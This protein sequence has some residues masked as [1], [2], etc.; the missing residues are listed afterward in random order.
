MRRLAAGEV[1][2]LVVAAAAAR[3]Q[4]DP[5]EFA[6]ELHGFAEPL[7]PA[8]ALD[9][10]LTSPLKRLGRPATLTLRWSSAQG[11]SGK[12]SFRATARVR[13]SYAVARRAL[14]ARTAIDAGVLE[15]IEGFLPGEPSEFLLWKQDVEGKKL[16][17]NLR[18][19]E[20]L[21]RR[22]LEQAPAVE[23]GALLE[24]ELRSRAVVLRAAARAEQAGSPGQVIR[25]RTLQSGAM[26][27]ARLRDARLGEVVP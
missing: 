22:M 10:E 18:P 23:R 11:Q 2:D 9:F 8:G 19:G 6:V 20:V 3:Y 26:V 14:A 7:L 13:G 5:A 24:L 4:V 27:R 16:K 1:R 21:E 25:C 15:F 12:L 17:Q